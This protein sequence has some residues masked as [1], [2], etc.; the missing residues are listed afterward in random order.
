VHDACRSL[1][2]WD[3]LRVEVLGDDESYLFDTSPAGFAYAGEEHEIAGHVAWELPAIR[4]LE[5]CAV[6][7]PA[8]THGGLVVRA[9]ESPLC[10]ELVERVT[11]AVTA[12]ERTAGPLPFTPYGERSLRGEGDCVRVSYQ[13]G[14][15]CA[16]HVDRDVPDDPVDAIREGEADPDVVCTAAL[17]AAAE[18]GVDAVATT[19]DFPG[20]D[21]TR[22]CNLA[23]GDREWEVAVRASR[24]D[25][26][27]GPTEEV[28]GHPTYMSV[29]PLYKIALEDTTDRGQLE[30]RFD[31]LDG[32]FDEPEWASP[33]LEALVAEMWG[34]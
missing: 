34:G 24:E 12:W 3:V 26:G 18:A 4:G 31:R 21:S 16:E 7:L 29:A 15:R 2:E 32:S 33:F 27:W 22:A 30:V 23:V 17:A 14:R 9:E 11:T 6:L 19:A 13:L 8:G 10:D 28:A 25:V 20:S 1:P 5:H